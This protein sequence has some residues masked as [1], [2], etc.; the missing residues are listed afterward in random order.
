MLCRASAA[1]ASLSGFPGGSSHPAAEHLEARLSA[2][3]HH[4]TLHGDF[5]NTPILRASPGSCQE[6]FKPSSEPSQAGTKGAAEGVA[7][8]WAENALDKTSK[9]GDSE[10]SRRG[11]A[12]DKRR[13]RGTGCGNSRP[14]AG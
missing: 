9:D 7:A 12:Q 13:P 11:Y 10:N 14:S 3:K 2:L 1:W 8:C 4:F 5:G 6:T